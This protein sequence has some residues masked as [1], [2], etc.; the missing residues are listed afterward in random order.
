M[1]KLGVRQHPS[2]RRRSRRTRLPRQ[3]READRR[4]QPRRRQPQPPADSHGN[5]LEHKLASH[6]PRSSPWPSLAALPR[7]RA[8]ILPSGAP[9]PPT[10]PVVEDEV[11]RGDRDVDRPLR[12]RRHPTRRTEKPV[13]NDQLSDNA[14]AGGSSASSRS[15]KEESPTRSGTED[16]APDCCA[17]L[18]ASPTT[19]SPSS[20]SEPS[21][22][23]SST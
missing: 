7:D 22:T 16:S 13:D 9:R 17:C 14:G 6:S 15:C 8:V 23:N 1:R 20:P 5:K 10:N 3:P 4:I 12:P 2:L 21:S 11:G 18:A 19:T